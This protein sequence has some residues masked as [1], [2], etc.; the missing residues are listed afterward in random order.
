MLLF[1]FCFSNGKWTPKN[2]AN[3]YRVVVRWAGLLLLTYDSPLAFQKER[4]RHEPEIFWKAEAPL[5]LNLA[6]AAFEHYFIG[7]AN[8]GLS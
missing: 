3:T 8:R 4:G 2:L 5:G 7:D 6:F 1:I